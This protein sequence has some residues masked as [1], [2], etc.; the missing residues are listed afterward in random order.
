[1]FLTTIPQIHNLLTTQK[2][3]NLIGRKKTKPSPK[4]KDPSEP[5]CLYKNTSD[6]INL[7]SLLRRYI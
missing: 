5:H 3:F 1:M 7:Q 2:D 4:V 6:I